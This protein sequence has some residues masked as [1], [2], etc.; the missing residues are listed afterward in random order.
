MN[1]FTNVVTSRVKSTGEIIQEM[2]YSGLND[3][4]GL[5]KFSGYPPHDLYQVGTGK[6]DVGCIINAP[7]IDGT[8]RPLRVIPGCTVVK[9]GDGS[10][11][12]WKI[13]DCPIPYTDM[14]VMNRS[15]III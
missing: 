14:E 8:I 12:T 5:R 11:E 15:M 3:I 6:F 13:S 9:R 10:I 7:D 4:D 2:E 1:T